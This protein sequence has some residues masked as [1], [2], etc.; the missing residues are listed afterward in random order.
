MYNYSVK[1][2]VLN[3]VVIV[4]IPKYLN[5]VYCG[6]SNVQSLVLVHRINQFYFYTTT[7]KTKL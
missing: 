4:N 2:Y 1:F 5:K 3:S 6:S 7:Y